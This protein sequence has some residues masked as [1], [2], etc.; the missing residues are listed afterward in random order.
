MMSSADHQALPM[1]GSRRAHTTAPFILTSKS[2]LLRGGHTALSLRV[3][4]LPAF[5][6]ARAKK[7][8]Q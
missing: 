3:T 2:H 7:S 1:P 4:L 6:S 8:P 5:A